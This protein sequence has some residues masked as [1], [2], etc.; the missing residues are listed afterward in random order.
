MQP[1][2]YRS[3]DGRTAVGMGDVSLPPLFPKAIGN[4]F[5][6]SVISGM[7]VKTVNGTI[8][9]KLLTKTVHIELNK[10]EISITFQNVSISA[11]PFVSI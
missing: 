2:A 8:N 11:Y 4:F 7:T 10:K 5:A 6:L 3:R 1:G 9:L